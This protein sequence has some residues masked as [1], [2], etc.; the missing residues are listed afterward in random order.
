MQWRDLPRDPSARTLRHPAGAGPERLFPGV[1]TAPRAEVRLMTDK[2]NDDFERLAAEQAERSLV[3]EFWDFL[4]YNKKWWLLP[5]VV[6]LLLF[7]LLVV[8][9]GSGA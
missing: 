9:S 4:R 6:V 8:L 1:L 7:A 3:G 2:R 5:V